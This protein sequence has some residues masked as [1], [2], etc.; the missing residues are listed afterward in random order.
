MPTSTYRFPVQ[1]YYFGVGGSVARFK[2]LVDADGGKILTA[3]HSPRAHPLH[4][5]TLLSHTEALYGS[6]SSPP[7]LHVPSA[8][9]RRVGHRKPYHSAPPLLCM[10]ARR[11]L[12]VSGCAHFRGWA[13]QPARSAAC[14]V[15][16]SPSVHRSCR[17]DIFRRYIVGE[18]EGREWRERRGGRGRRWKR[19]S[20][21]GSREREQGQCREE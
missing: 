20:G 8:L 12:R 14:L 6:T 7:A 4:S 5:P 1:S 3:P 16:A 11:P 10:S 15:G 18:G 2:S 13:I 21:T 17:R 9:H 19:G